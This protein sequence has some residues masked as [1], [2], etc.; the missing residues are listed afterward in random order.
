M[1]RRGFARACAVG[2]G[3]LMLNSM[4]AQEQR[5]REKEYTAPAG[6]G[7]G[8][9]EWLERATASANQAP[10]MKKT[11]GLL[12]F[13]RFKDRIY[14]LQQPMSWTPTPYIAE[15]QGYPSVTVPKGFVTDLASIPR[16]FYSI[17]PPDGEYTVPAVIH[18]YLY[19][20]QTTTK[21]QADN[22]LRFSMQDYK[23]GPI[24]R[25][26]IYDA[27]HVGGGSAW[28]ENTRL[29]ERGEKR[30]LTQLPSDSSTT[31]QEWKRDPGHFSQPGVVHPR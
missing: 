2:I 3:G 14:V 13:S 12:V 6:D 19:W 5:S 26:V 1:D 21:E 28:A 23:I 18:D 11:G 29:Q 16:I 9:D 4:S 20:T 7:M 8:R 27:V 17:L 10:S 15:Q 30:I 24:T 31:W 25:T 22:I